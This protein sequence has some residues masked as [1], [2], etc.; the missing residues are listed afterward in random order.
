MDQPIK[1]LQPRLAPMY[2]HTQRQYNDAFKTGKGTDA[3]DRCITAEAAFNTNEY[4]SSKKTKMKMLLQLVL[5][6][7]EAAN[8]D[9]MIKAGYIAAN[10]SEAVALTKKKSLVFPVISLA[11]SLLTT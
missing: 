8:Y 2:K 3:L 11:A 4:P 10:A 1:P 9:N 5:G 7:A 6:G